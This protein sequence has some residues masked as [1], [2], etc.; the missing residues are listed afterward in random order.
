MKKRPI[1]YDLHLPPE[2][3]IMGLKT[4]TWTPSASR[5]PECGQR[6]VFM[7]LRGTQ[8]HGTYQGDNQWDADATEDRQAHRIQYTPSVWRA[9][10]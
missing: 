8:L 2:L 1:S 5:L 4:I 7:N 3:P 6:V 10:R 9:E